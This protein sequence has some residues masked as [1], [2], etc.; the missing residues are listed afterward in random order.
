MRFT[1]VLVVVLLA[2]SPSLAR[3]QQ[4]PPDQGT[5]GLASTL[6]WASSPSGVVYPGLNSQPFGTEHLLGDWWGARTW[7]EDHGIYVGLN[8]YPEVAAIIAGGQQQGVDY[9]SQIGLSVDLDGQKMFG[10]NGFAIHNVIVQRNGR[11]ASADFLD[12]DLDAVQ[13]IFGGGGSVAAHLVYLYAEQQFY[14]GRVNIAGGWLPV[15]SYFGAS[16]IYCQF[17]N[18]IFCG[19]PHPLPVYPGEP[20]WP[21]ASWGGLARVFVLPTFYVMGGVFQVNPNNGGPSGWDLF[22]HGTTGVSVPLEVGW[23][24]SFGPNQLIGHY[25]VGFDNDSS[26]YPNLYVSANGLPIAVSGLAGQQEHGRRMYYVMADQMLMRFG[27][28]DMNGLIAFG[29]FVHADADVSPFEQQVFAGLLANASF[30]GRP[31]DSLG[32]ATSWFQVSGSLTATQQLEAALGEPLTGGGLGTPV[33]VQSHEQELEVM[34]SAH[35]YRGVFI[36]P[37]L[38]YIINPGGTSRTHNGLALGL[39]LNVTF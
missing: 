35:A 14:S 39:Q 12:D 33:G 7:L 24:P 28:G 25:K 9:T 38:Q 8:Y 15:G 6:Q 31:Q 4:P 11:S 18:V 36:E 19:N 20:D 32:F 2:L 16:P 37:D 22:I 21:A 26:S 13:Q 30:I 34:Y 10:L 29:G 17:I 5:G 23:T 27:Q 3:A 1:A